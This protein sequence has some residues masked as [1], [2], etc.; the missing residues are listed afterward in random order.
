MRFF[1]IG[2]SVLVIVLRGFFCTVNIRAVC[3]AFALLLFRKVLL[4]GLLYATCKYYIRVVNHYCKKRT[5]VDK[6]HFIRVFGMTLT[7]TFALSQT[8]VYC[9]EIKETLS[10]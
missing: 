8:T 1:D 2:M 9:T 6:F 5:L 3:T 10:Q 7:C 4:H